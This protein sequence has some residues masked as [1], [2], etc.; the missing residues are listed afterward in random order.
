MAALDRLATGLGN[1]GAKVQEVQPEAFGDLRDYYKLYLSIFWA[2]SSAGQP[3]EERRR[4]AADFRASG[5]EFVATYAQG[6]E[7]SASDYLI[8]FGRREHYRAAYRSFFRD[9]DVLLAPANIVNAF[10]HTSWSLTINDEPGDY[11]R[12]FAYPSLANLSGQ[13]ATAFPI[14]RTAGG[15]P[16]GLQA[17]GPY[18]EDKTPIRFTG[19]VAEAFGG[20]VAP[21]G[22]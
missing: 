1:A 16:I 19:L 14:G 6:L 8:W 10:P 9:W 11:N 7:A 2:M 13:P 17:I 22:Y 3:E 5:D 18:L 21:E 12:Q 15:L 4:Q 20:Y